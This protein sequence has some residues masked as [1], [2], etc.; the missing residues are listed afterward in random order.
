MKRLRER[1]DNVVGFDLSAP[2]PPP[3]ECVRIAVDISSDDSV[4]D[5]MCMLREH[6]GT[7]I[8]AVVHLAACY[9]FDGQPSA[10]Y[11]EITVNGTRRLLRGL[12]ENFEVEQFI[13]T[14]TML[15]HSPGVQTYATARC[16]V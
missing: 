9:N 15:V 13:F 4:R 16:R 11:D 8:A 12:H 7:K 3:H 5:G 6:H 1:F 10:K 2:Q 14:G